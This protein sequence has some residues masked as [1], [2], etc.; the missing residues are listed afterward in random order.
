MNGYKK[1]INLQFVKENTSSFHLLTCS[2]L[3]TI[4]AASLSRVAWVIE[5]CHNKQQS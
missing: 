2:L 3:I 1:L 5:M 4:K